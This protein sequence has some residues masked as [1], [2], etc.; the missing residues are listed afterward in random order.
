MADEGDSPIFPAGDVRVEAGAL[1]G[2]NLS[3]SAPAE[4]AGRRQTGG[5]APRDDDGKRKKKQKRRR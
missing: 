4:K 2:K 1:S 5:T 3:L